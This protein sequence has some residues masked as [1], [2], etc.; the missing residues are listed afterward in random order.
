MKRILFITTVTML[1]A[2]LTAFA[3]NGKE[4]ADDGGAIPVKVRNDEIVKTGWN[5]GLLPAF[6]YNN[7]LG[8]MGGVL[9]QVFHYGDGTDYPEYRHKFTVLASIYSKGAKQLSLDYDSKHLLVGRRITAHVEYMD[10]PLCGFYGFNGAV[11]PYHADLDLR[12]SSNG[13]DGIAFYADYQRKFMASL[14]LQGRLNDHLN[15]IGGASYSYQT[16]SDVSIH[17]YDG[18]QTLFHQYVE[19]GLIP[20]GDTWGHRLGLKAGVLFDTRD[21]EANPERGVYASVTLDGGASF[22]SL[23]R[24]SLGFSADFRHYVPVLPSRLTF[25]YQLS[26]SSLLAGS[27]PFHALPA[28][29]MRGSFGSRITG[30]GVAWASADLRLKAASFNALRQNIELGLVAFADA[31]AVVKPYR[32]A[33][34]SQLG[35]YLMSKTLDGTVSGPYRTVFDTDIAVRERLHASAGGGFFYSMNH[36]FIT[37]VELGRPLNPQDGTMGVYVNLGFSF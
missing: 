1:T 16:Y 20:E 15:W 17:P 26:C 11:S 36:N 35:D 14:D 8:F 13:E 7:D 9:G 32:I 6:N 10:N 24:A 28:F 30:A 31:G 3:G 5:I 18:T 19:S 33:E 21:F 25:A 12:K 23:K 29:A 34:Q 37:V 4:S 2:S 27:L 22:S